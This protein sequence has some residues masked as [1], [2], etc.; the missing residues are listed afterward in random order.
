MFDGSRKVERFSSWYCNCTQ[1][2]YIFIRK[3]IFVSIS[4]DK[5]FCALSI[6]L[7]TWQLS[8]HIN[9]ILANRYIHAVRQFITIKFLKLLLVGLKSEIGA[10]RKLKET[11]SRHE[12]FVH[13]SVWKIYDISHHILNRMRKKTWY[14]SIGKNWVGCSESQKQEFPCIHK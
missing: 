10:Q 6:L 13:K 1:N 7:C 12:V 8:K 4:I 14:I 5:S 3:F 11:I 9:S 2:A